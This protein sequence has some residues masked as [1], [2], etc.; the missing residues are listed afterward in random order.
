MPL[1]GSVRASVAGPPRVGATRT[2]LSIQKHLGGHAWK[3]HDPEIVSAALVGKR[4]EK[5]NCGVR[6]V[7]C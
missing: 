5:G 2:C 1:T 6:F 7:G 3:T 4:E